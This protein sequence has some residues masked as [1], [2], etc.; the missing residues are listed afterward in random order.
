MAG[1]RL[2]GLS[3]LPA[4]LTPACHPHSCLH[5]WQGAAWLASSE[6]L[7]LE[8]PEEMRAEERQQVAQAAQ[9]ASS[10]TSRALHY[11]NYTKILFIRFYIYNYFKLH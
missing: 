6:P 1:R 9:Q 8:L 10:I 11:I 5:P 4:T 2:A 7:V 3:L